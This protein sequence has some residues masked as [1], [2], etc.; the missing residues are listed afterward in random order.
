MTISQHLEQRQTQSLV[1][2]PQLQQA[3][4]ILELSNID[5]SSYLETEILTNPLLTMDE[6]DINPEDAL[7]D[8]TGDEVEDFDDVWS[9]E[10]MSDRSSTERKE[11]S[12]PP[13]NSLDHLEAQPLS[14][15]E[16][17]LS[18]LSTDITDP[19][20]KLIGSY[21]IGILEDTGYFPKDYMDQARKMGTN[22]AR[23]EA[24]ITLLQQFD[25]AGVFARNLAECL[26]LQLQDRGVLTKQTQAVLDNLDLFEQGAIEKLLHKCGITKDDLREI[27]V[28]IR[29][30]DPKPGLKFTSFDTGH[31][32]PDII[33]LGNP[34]AGWHLKL[35]DQTLPRVMIDEAYYANL[36][37]GKTQN[38]YVN[39][40]YHAANALLKALNQRALTIVS[41]TEQILRI[42]SEFFEKGIHHLKPMTL[43]DIARETQLHESTISRVTTNKYIQTPRG[44]FELKFFFT[45]S[46]YSLHQEDEMSSSSVRERIKEIIKAEDR[47]KP[48]SD[49]QLVKVLNGEGTLVARRTITKYRESMDIP[50]SFQRKRRYACEL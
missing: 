11:R 10:S 23:I 19:T 12:A 21:L 40:K 41:V 39:E 44:T 2:T 3:I 33:L 35:N 38:S 34:E 24:T 7:A 29:L 13:T 32:V 27:M 9:E 28:Q 46:I 4:K 20:D 31:I 45:S 47:S 17:L 6:Q 43:Q 36:K 14:L 16:H 18:Q 22:P 48:L 42:Q 5:L 1:M 25:P 15:K 8:E 30:C 37:Q 26:T 50:S 49:D